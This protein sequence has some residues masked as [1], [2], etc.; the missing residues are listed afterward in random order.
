MVF[1]NFYGTVNKD[2]DEMDF[3]SRQMFHFMRCEV[4][5]INQQRLLEGRSNFCL[6]GGRTNKI[7]LSYQ[8][9]VN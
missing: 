2:S 6:P 7:H 5:R 4:D 1:L 9:M 3:H 8:E